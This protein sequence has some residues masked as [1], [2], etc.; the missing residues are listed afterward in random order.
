[1]GESPST[2]L[3]EVRFESKEM[4][5]NQHEALSLVARG[6]GRGAL[7]ITVARRQGVSGV[8]LAKGVNFLLF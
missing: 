3:P 2:T 8:K 5:S 7:G 6:R 4:V 1:M